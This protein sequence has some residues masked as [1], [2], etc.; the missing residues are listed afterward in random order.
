MIEKMNKNY[1]LKR[2]DEAYIYATRVLNRNELIDF[3]KAA[4]FHL[5]IE[6]GIKNK[7][8]AKY[9]QIYWTT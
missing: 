2:F 8:L 9:L 4:L 5:E 7:S 3:G 6:H 1:K